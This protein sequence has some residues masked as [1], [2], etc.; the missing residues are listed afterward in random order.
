MLISDLQN[1][2]I[3]IW[4][5]GQ[6]GA[7]VLEFLLR[8][9]IGKKLSV[10]N[11]SPVEKPQ[12]AAGV[13]F[14]SGADF[15]K[16]LSVTDVIVKSPGVS[17]YKE[18]IRRAKERGIAVTSSTDLFLSEMRRRPQTV[19]IG[20]TGSKGKST[21]SSMLYHVL[22][23]L[24]KDAAL[25]GNIGAPLISLLDK[26]CDYVVMELSSYQCS[27]LSVSPQIVLFTNLFPEHID[28]HRSH[29]AYYRDKVHLIAHQRP[30]DVC[31]L[32][33]KCEKLKKYCAEYPREFLY[34]N[35][36]AGFAKIN[37]ILCKD[38]CPLMYME[39]LKLQGYHNLD[40]IAGVLSIIDYLKL[41]VTRAVEALKTFEPLPHRL[42][43]VGKIGD[44]E[45]INDSISTAPETAI[46]AMSSFNRPLALI[47][48]GYD[49][50]QDYNEL[51]EKINA[52]S[53]VKV[54]ATLFKT[55]PRIAET[56]R[57]HLT[58][59]VK[60]IKETDLTKAVEDAYA[61]LC[62]QKDGLVLFSPAAPSYDAYKSFVARGNHFIEI[63]KEL[64]KK[65]NSCC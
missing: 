9:G 56:L 32:N 45:F 52:D 11:D 21:T 17:I 35:R 8:H 16:L 30:E 29:E 14:F 34:Y 10:Y 49:R 37:N 58:R 44:I 43:K 20:V 38:G 4:G 23:N 3:V 33:E 42:Q 55:G 59:E 61:G 6:E 64:S 47:L 48:G 15:E 50:N 51:A 57:R 31:F 40:N 53:N 24:G 60:L 62:G 25:G 26:T 27:D 19:T 36:S 28:W 18:E 5:L 13:E 7:A 54:V 46:A 12:E 2:N 39:D 22:K 65:Q 41:D 63:V 1:K